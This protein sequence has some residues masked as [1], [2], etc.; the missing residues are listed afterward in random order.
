[1]PSARTSAGNKYE[2]K[3]KKKETAKTQQIAD[4]LLT[5]QF[6]D[7]AMGGALRHVLDRTLRLY[8]LSTSFYD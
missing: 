6:G 1:M 5:V 8:D 7:A 3:G 2:Y 4:R